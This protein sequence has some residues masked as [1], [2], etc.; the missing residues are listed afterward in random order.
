LAGV[1]GSDAH[2]TKLPESHPRST[3]DVDTFGVCVQP[4]DWYLGLA[5]YA[6]KARQSWDTAGDHYDHLIHDVRKF[7]RLLI[8]GNP[9]VHCWLWADPE[10]IVLVNLAG[11][12]ILDNREAFLSRRCFDALAGYAKAQMHKMDRKRCQGCQGKKRKL[13]VDELGYDVKHAA[14]CIR[15]LGMGIELAETGRMSTR[16]PEGEAATLMEIKAGEW[17]Y[18]KTEKL[19]QDLWA[20][21]KHAEKHSSLPAEPDHQLAHHLLMTAIKE[22]V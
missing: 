5:G 21:F 12:R 10:D 8:K 7:V 17:P 6:G 4:V 2:G 13:L 20:T 3:D 11:R 16:R 22:Q 19:A 9:N 15:L 1:R 18:R 14:H